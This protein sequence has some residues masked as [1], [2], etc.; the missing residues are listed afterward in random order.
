M[1]MAPY[2][3]YGDTNDAQSFSFHIF[4]FCTA[5]CDSELHH[6]VLSLL[7]LFQRDE[8]QS[9]KKQKKLRLNF[10]DPFIESFINPPMS[11]PYWSVTSCYPVVIG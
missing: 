3:E 6:K 1:S 9:F 10:I 4:R 7:T 5:V 2:T 8:T 11:I